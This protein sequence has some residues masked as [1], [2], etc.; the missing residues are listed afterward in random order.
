MGLRSRNPSALLV[1]GQRIPP[2]I[3]DSLPARI[4]SVR[5]AQGEFST[6]HFTL[7]SALTSF[8]SNTKPTTT[9]SSSLTSLGGPCPW[10]TE[11]ATSRCWSSQPGTSVLIVTLTRPFV[12]ASSSASISTETVQALVTQSPVI[13]HGPGNSLTRPEACWKV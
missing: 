9:L 4:Y 1:I 5:E 11:P 12:P 8:C 3:R 10:T 7:A 2:L 6:S 13:S